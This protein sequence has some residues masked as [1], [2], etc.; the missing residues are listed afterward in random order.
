ML[1]LQAGRGQDLA[2]VQRLLTGVNALEHQ[3][4]RAEVQQ[5][6]PHA[7]SFFACIPPNRVALLRTGLGRCVA[8]GKQCRPILF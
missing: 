4:I 3:R 2:D 7:L 5:Y 6:A 1:K 8:K